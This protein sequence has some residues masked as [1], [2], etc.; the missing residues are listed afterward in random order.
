MALLVLGVAICVRPGSGQ[1]TAALDGSQHAATDNGGTSSATVVVGP[2][3]PTAGDGITCEV[4]SSTGNSASTF[5]SVADNV[6]AA[7]YTAATAWTFNSA[8]GEW[9]AIFYKSGVAGRATTITFTATVAHSNFAMSCEAWKP[10]STPATFTLDP[11]TVQTNSVTTATANPTSGTAVTPAHANEVLIGYLSTNNAP[12]AFG[13]NYTSVDT[14][15]STGAFPEYWIQTAV[16]ATDAPYAMAA[17]DWT[18]AQAGFYFVA[19]SPG[20]SAWNG[21][22]VG[23]STGNIS[24]VDGKAI[25]PAVGSY[26]SWNGLQAPGS[27]LI[28]T[29][30]QHP[31]TYGCTS[32]PCSVAVSSTGAGHGIVMWS[33][34]KYSGSGSGTSLYMTAPTGESGW[35][36]CPNSI[37][38]SN[39]A[40]SPAYALQ[41]WY[42]PGAGG[43]VTSLSANWTS[44]GLTSSSIVIDADVREYNDSISP[45]YDSGGVIRDMFTCTSCAGP[46][47]SLSGTSDIV[48]QAAIM[49]QAPTGING[50]YAGTQL[51]ID[52]TSIFSAYTDALNQ[53]SY[54]QPTW[55]QGVAS[56]PDY[57]SFAAFS[58][59]ATP[60]PTFDLFFDMSGGTNGTAPNPSTLSA[61]TFTAVGGIGYN[62]G[63]GKP[64]LTACNSGPSSHIPITSNIAGVYYT[65]SSTL[66]VCGVT[67]TTGTNIGYD[68]II[69]GSASPQ[70]SIS[71]GFTIESSCPSGSSDCGALGGIAFPYGDYDYAEVHFNCEASGDLGKISL[72]LSTGCVPNSTIPYAA[73]TPY[74]INIQLTQGPSSKENMTV[75]ADG[76]GGAV[77][78]TL[79]GTGASGAG[80]NFDAAIGLTG[81]EPKTSG[82]NYY[83][84][85]V[86]VST[87][88]QYS[89]TS[90]F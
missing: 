42:T 83:W 15:A 49:T 55:M 10:S 45:I 80:Q 63:A 53:A 44:A 20:W 73:N 16:T 69:F 17:G 8:T 19:A 33:A 76:P 27:A 39:I 3:T 36:Q 7:N 72:E 26:V 12:T 54:A 34:A 60:T 50:L 40:Y 68:S 78:G 6:N 24:S 66:N 46:A 52:S 30:V 74:R 37:V 70:P 29:L 62:T 71:I 11:A 22:T 18:D 47:G 79:S 57:F 85:N 65:G 28:A 35:K 67:S 21:V 77:L 4:T 43:G 64:G 31:H 87:T 41:C 90:C 23:A 88:G 82:Y 75:C 13:P 38:G 9:S 56:E 59:T 5:S 51:D 61:S 86:I 25:G 58:A 2:I 32:S 89:T 84:R 14:A 1:V 81:E 48:T